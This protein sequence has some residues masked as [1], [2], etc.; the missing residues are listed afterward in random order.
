MQWIAGA[1]LMYTGAHNGLNAWHR[2][3]ENWFWFCFII[4]GVLS[5][6]WFLHNGHHAWLKG[7]FT[8]KQTRIFKL[9][10]SLFFFFIVLGVLTGAQ[11]ADGLANQFIDFHYHWILPVGTVLLLPA[12]YHLNSANEITQ[13]KNAGANLKILAA[14]EK[15]RE[16]H[17]AEYM[18]L[19]KRRDER[20]HIWNLRKEL[21]DKTHDL[22]NGRWTGRGTRKQIDVK[23]K[24]QVPLLLEKAGIAQQPKK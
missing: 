15:E 1:L 16:K 14:A 11:V 9:W 6:E 7:E 2:A 21:A 18:E 13:A 17:E 19:M 4:L 20:I 23:A 8:R 22:I 3:G 24:E 12:L 10:G 5:M